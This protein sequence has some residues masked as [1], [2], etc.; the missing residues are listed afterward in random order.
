MLVRTVH[1]ALDLHLTAEEVHDLFVVSGDL[2]QVLMDIDLQH[3]ESG[4]G[5]GNVEA[6]VLQL[7]EVAGHLEHL[8]A[9]ELPVRQNARDRRAGI[10]VD[11]AGVENVILDGLRLIQLAGLLVDEDADAAVADV[12]G[13]RCA[14]RSA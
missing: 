3:A 12:V 9:H 7:G 6:K 10:R 11:R 13:S 1:A 5:D 4:V 14:Y 2:V 8:L